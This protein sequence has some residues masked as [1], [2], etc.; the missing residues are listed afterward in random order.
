MSRNVHGGDIYSEENA[1]VI[2]FSVNI[3]PLGAP[4]SVKRAVKKAAGHFSAYP[5]PLCRSLCGAIS[6]YEGVPRAAVF[7]SNGASEIFYRIAWGFPLQKCS[8]Y[9]ACF[10]RIPSSSGKHRR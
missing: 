8:C 9:G 7:C 6:E 5:D 4:E 10:F 2:D 3:N 1:G